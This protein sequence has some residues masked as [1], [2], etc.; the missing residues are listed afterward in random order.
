MVFIF[1][2]LFCFWFWFF[3]FLPLS[4]CCWYSWEKSC[5][6]GREQRSTLFSSFMC[7]FYSFIRPPFICIFFVAIRTVFFFP[8]SR[9][10]FCFTNFFDAMPSHFCVTFSTRDTNPSFNK[11]ATY[12]LALGLGIFVQFFSG[13]FFL[14]CPAFF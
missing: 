14:L 12:L 6:C 4:S 13:L 10:F 9:S 2:F 7:V 8:C 1:L 5:A 11:Y 3:F